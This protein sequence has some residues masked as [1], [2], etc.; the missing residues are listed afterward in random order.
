MLKGTGE[1]W[2]NSW[3]W[4]WGAG[5]PLSM[6]QQRSCQSLQGSHRKGSGPT[7]PTLRATRGSAWI[8]AAAAVTCPVWFLLVC[9]LWTVRGASSL[10]WELDTA[11]LGRKHQGWSWRC[12]WQQFLGCGTKSKDNTIKN[13][14]DFV[15]VKKVLYITG[16][17][18]ESEKTTHR[19]GENICKSYIWSGINI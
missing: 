9:Y 19:M 18:Q 1:F 7:G 4:I 12:I 11:T 5:A 10:A 15:R 3:F 14:L 13:K 6:G 17:C 16:H 2:R 8:S